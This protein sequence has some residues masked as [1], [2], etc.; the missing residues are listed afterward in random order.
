MHMMNL[1]LGTVFIAGLLS[2][3]TP[4]VLPMLPAY[5]TLLFGSTDQPKTFWQ[6][7]IN[8]LCFLAA[9]CLVFVTMGATAGLLS[10]FFWQ[11]QDLIRQIGAIF[12]IVMGLYMIGVFNITALNYEKRPLLN[13]TFTGPV[14]AFMFG[15]GLTAGW[16]PCSGPILGSVLLYASTTETASAGAWL[17]FVY[18]LGFCVPFLLLSVVTKHY[19]GSLRKSYKYLPLIHKISGLLIVIL[20]GLLL[21]DKLKLLNMFT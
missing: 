15:L 3:F 11:Y 21:F 2:F 6:A 19:A 12:M 14:G 17:L 20:G 5:S 10:D 4:C 9:F 8:T 13:K 7:L 16:T 1:S 18:S